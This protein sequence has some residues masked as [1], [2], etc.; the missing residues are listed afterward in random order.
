MSMKQKV[1]LLN[2][3]YEPVKIVSPK[4]AICL[5]MLGKVDT[6]EESDSFLRSPSQEVR[7]PSVIR[8]KK[9]VKRQKVKLRMSKANV[10]ALYMNRGCAYC[11]CLFYSPDE[12][13]IDHVVP[14]A[15]GGRTE[16]TNM[17]G[18][19]EP[20]NRRKADRT[21]EQARMKLLYEPVEPPLALT[22]MRAAR[23]HDIP[24]EWRPYFYMGE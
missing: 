20:C 5:Q 12:F 7:I 1:L 18:A 24:Q 21:P 8:Y 23:L 6:I 16:W 13:T 10:F 22:I 3:A 11:G 2:A 14:R 9:F 15:K 4:R 19:C 17:V